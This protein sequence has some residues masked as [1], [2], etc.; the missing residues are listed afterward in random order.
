DAS[1]A[2]LF[3]RDEYLGRRRI[4]SIL[5]LPIVKQAKLVGIL[6]LENNLTADAFTSE[7]IAVLE[8]LAS[9]AAISLEHAQ[10][11]AD[12]QQE[13][14]ERKRA[15]DELRRS[16][17]S[18][19][20]AQSELARVTRLTT[21]G[22]MAASIAHEVNQ[23]LAGVVT[24]ANASLRWLAGDSPNLAEARE[25]IRRILRDGNRAGVVTQ[26]IRALFTKTHT[27]ERLDI[28]ETIGE[29][30]VLTESHMQRERITLETQLAANLPPIM[31]DR[32]QLQQVVLNLIL[33]GMEAMS[34]VQ[35][36][37]RELVIRTQRSEGAVC[38]A[39]QDTGI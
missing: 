28:N 36:R 37:P 39:V 27:A 5:C 3:S 33:N 30:V 34:I 22:E 24:N 11:Y 18:L 25:A 7:R 38:V 6:Y 23:P 4:R 16:E 21:M 8:L 1:V 15:E 13:N 12:L 17:A 19:R 9:Q 10:L 2:N 29:V 14:I 32:V 26:R 20:E 31:G 35:D